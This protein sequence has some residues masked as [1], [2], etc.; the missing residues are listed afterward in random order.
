MELFRPDRCDKPA[1]RNRS[2]WGEGVAVLCPKITGVIVH[3]R[4]DV[5]LQVKED[6]Q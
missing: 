2:N 3:K 6:L 5:G 4:S 1:G